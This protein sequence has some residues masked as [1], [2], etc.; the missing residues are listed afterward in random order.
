MDFGYIFK[1]LLRG[2]WLILTAIIVPA[3]AAFM[4]VSTLEKTFKSEALISTGVLGSA[5][6]DPEE[7]RPYLQSDLIK[8][9]FN[10]YVT[11]IQSASM[12]RLLGYKMLIHELDSNNEPFRKLDPE[13][14]NEVNSINLQR[15]FDK[16]TERY[17]NL[18]GGMFDAS[19]EKD[20]QEVAEAFNFDIEALKDNLTVYRSGET[21]YLGITYKSEDKYL[22]AYLV[23]ELCD[24]FLSTM[25][26]DQQKELVEKFEFASTES[27]QARKNLDSLKNTLNAYKIQHNILD[28]DAEASELIEQ[29][30]GIQQLQNE[31][32]TDLPALQQQLAEIE[33]EQNLSK[34]NKVTRRI[35]KREDSE[36]LIYIKKQITKLEEEYIITKDEALRTD[37]DMLKRQRDKYI[38][39]YSEVEITDANVVD[40]DEDREKLILSKKMAYINAV[41][42]KTAISEILGGAKTRAR[43]LV[44]HNAFISKLSNELSIAEEAYENFK[45]EQRDAKSRLDKSSFPLK[46]REQAYVAKK[47]ESNHKALISA[48]SGVVGGAFASMLLLMLAFFDTSLNSANQFEKFTDLNLVGTLNQLKEKNFDLKELFGAE[49]NNKSLEVFKESIRS[50]RYEIEKSSGSS[51]LFTST[52]EQEGK[53]FV[54]IMLAHALTLKGKKVLIIDTN[55]KNNSL[56]RIFNEDSNQNK[57]ASRLIGEANLEQEFETKN[58]SGTGQFKLDN[59]DI[60]GNRGGMSSPSEIFAGK[61]FKKLVEDFEHNYDYIFLEGPSLNKYADSKELTEYVDKVITVFS[62]DANIT[63]ADRK[64]ISYLQNLNGKLMGAVLNKLEMINLN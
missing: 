46:I 52:K 60:L 47:P 33:K 25:K 55:F 54:I 56:T 3:I 19:V 53:T 7:D 58:A 61:E 23:N 34:N 29:I 37:I 17:E 6:L 26:Y 42:S 16:M 38:Q 50:M 32:L 2:K 51:F 12:L 1:I 64:S 63:D 11:K 35:N 8:M 30:G 9:S 20:Y 41:S 4:Y 21:D 10:T 24:L 15:L 62:A 59:V 22:S 14:V 40:I 57:L 39:N 44:R 49:L 48:F 5:G 36:D 45:E 27:Q 13:K 31:A 18:D 43:A 28:L